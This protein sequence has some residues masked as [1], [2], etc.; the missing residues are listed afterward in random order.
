MNRS[1][2]LRDAWAPILASAAALVGLA[3]EVASAKATLFEA[4]SGAANPLLGRDAG[5]RSAPAV[6]DLDGDGDL[7]VVAGHLGTSFSYYENT[8]STP[9]PTFVE[10][11]GAA[12]PFAGAVAGATA[13]P[14]LGDLDA[15]GDLD[16]IAGTSAGSFDYFEN[17]GTAASPAFALRVG[18]ANP[19][20]GQDVGSFAAAALGDLDGDGDLDL[21]AGEL[22]GA[23]AWFENTGTRTAPVFVRRTGAA[24][25]LDGQDVGSNATPSV[26]DTDGDGDLDLAVGSAAGGFQSFENTG[27]AGSPR[28]ES[29]IAAANPFGDLGGGS[30]TAPRLADLDRDGDLDLVSGGSDGLFGYA[31]N[32]AGDLILRAGASSPLSGLVTGGDST[33]AFGDLDGDG[34]LDLVVGESGGALRSYANTGSAQAPVYVE[35]IGA[36]N[37]L[38]G[39]DVGSAS[40]PALGDLDRD[41]DLDL[42]VGEN[43]GVFNY[44]ENTGTPALANFS[45]RT[46]AL[47][48]LN[49]QN[50]G[51]L[52]TP[53]FGD[54]DRDGDLDL[55]AGELDGVFDYYEN[56]GTATSP[57]FAARAGSENPLDG[58]D[59]GSR[60]TLSLGD[61]G[62]DGDQDVVA[63]SAAGTFAWYENT[64]LVSAPVLTA[65][66]AAD[67][68]KP[69][70][71][72]TPTAQTN[73]PW[74]PSRNSTSSG[75]AS[76]HRM[77]IRPAM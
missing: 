71:I 74:R 36:A 40:A 14:A 19:V 26:G 73:P 22:A 23:F 76:P 5:D 59:V 28:F 11:T 68:R 4:R 55:V 29:R 34:D 47:N 6:A 61:L 66:P 72:T 7:D 18:A 33:P 17:T 30:L 13:N 53:A 44:F 2:S 62:G 60:S 9:S 15:D 35:R 58:Q 1:G 69:A 54:L 16:L 8:A 37:P 49:G 75:V 45:L 32:L 20:T 51:N 63:G 65:A 56:T 50:V 21:V 43:D 46:G 38:A 52:S 70:V 12:N 27:S 10:R 24:N 31:E 42:V 41:G 48:P 67:N 64:A 3:A 39:Q 77:R 57:V 25:P